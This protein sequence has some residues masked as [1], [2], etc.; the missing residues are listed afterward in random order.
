MDNTI[1]A[2]SR[3]F[4]HKIVLPILEQEFP[5]LTS[6][7]VQFLSWFV[8]RWQQDQKVYVANKGEVNCGLTLMIWRSN[9]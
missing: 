3:R 6:A 5:D 7:P 8:L 2:V 1:I 9:R 4:F